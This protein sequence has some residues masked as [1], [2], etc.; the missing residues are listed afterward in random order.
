M[1]KDQIENVDTCVHTVYIDK[2]IVNQLY[3]SMRFVIK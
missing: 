3:Y 1:K 2:Q